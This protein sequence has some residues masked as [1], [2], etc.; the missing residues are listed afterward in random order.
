MKAIEKGKKLALPKTLKNSV[1][2]LLQ[3]LES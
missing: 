2:V 1:L 3:P